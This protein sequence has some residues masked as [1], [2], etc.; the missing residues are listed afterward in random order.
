MYKGTEV[1]DDVIWNVAPLRRKYTN[2]FERWDADTLCT[3]QYTLYIV[4]T[5]RH[6]AVNHLQPIVELHQCSKDGMTK[7]RDLHGF[8]VR[9]AFIINGNPAVV[10]VVHPALDRAATLGP[11]HRARFTDIVNADVARAYDERYAQA[12]RRERAVPIMRRAVRHGDAR[13][14]WVVRVPAGALKQRRGE[15]V[16]QVVG[17][18]AH[19]RDLFV[20]VCVQVRRPRA[21]SRYGHLQARMVAVW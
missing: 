10:I 20:V 2:D 18:H 4:G 21:D 5:L 3:Q 9:I 1:P 15:W 14:W 11:E 6:G 13:R 12:T 17:G 8:R 7:T 19:R 16:D